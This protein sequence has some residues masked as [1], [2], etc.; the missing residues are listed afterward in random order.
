MDEHPLIATIIGLTGIRRFTWYDIKNRDL[1]PIYKYWKR[2][3]GKSFTFV[4]SKFMNEHYPGSRQI[5]EIDCSKEL[6]SS[7]EWA[8]HGRALCNDKLTIEEFIKLWGICPKI[9][10]NRRN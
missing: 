4:D 2:S 8:N 5:V 3:G 10:N 7:A 6:D 9:I 1:T